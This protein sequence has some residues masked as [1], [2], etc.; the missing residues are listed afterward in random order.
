MFQEQKADTC[1]NILSFDAATIGELVTIKNRIGAKHDII[2]SN[3]NSITFLSNWCPPLKLITMLSLS[4]PIILF[5][6]LSE[7]DN[8]LASKSYYQKGLLEYR[9]VPFYQ[10][11]ILKEFTWHRT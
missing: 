3:E 11:D 7:V 5:T 4:L 6:L 9:E 8:R 10:R 2:S 1:V